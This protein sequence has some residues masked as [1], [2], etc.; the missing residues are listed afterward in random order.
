[1]GECIRVNKDDLYTF[2]YRLRWSDGTNID[3]T[4]FTKVTLVMYEDATGTEKLRREM[5]MGE[6]GQVSYTWA[7]AGEPTVPETHTPGMYWIKFEL[8]DDAGHKF[9]VPTGEIQWLWIIG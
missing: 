6:N 5:V 7:E 4:E 1:M 2:T 9:T 3:L 8:E